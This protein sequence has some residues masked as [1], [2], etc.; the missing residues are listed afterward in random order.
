VQIEK[1]YA[2]FIFKIIGG[3]GVKNTDHNWKN[4]RFGPISTAYEDCK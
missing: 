4:S 2:T 1:K 3:G